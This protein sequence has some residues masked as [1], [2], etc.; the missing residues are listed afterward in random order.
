MESEA[1][2]HRA[3]EPETQGQKP[4]QLSIH[5]H[6]ITTLAP[7]DRPTIG[8][9]GLALAE[10]DLYHGCAVRGIT[11]RCALVNVLQELSCILRR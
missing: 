11:R 8:L 6:K 2:P 9:F 4:L 10:I 7:A 3:A 5:Q 1:F